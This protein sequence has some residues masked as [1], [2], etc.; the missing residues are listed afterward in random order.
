MFDQKKVLFSGAAAG[1]IALLAFA[2]LCPACSRSSTG[3][4]G[5]TTGGHSGWSGT[6]GGTLLWGVNN[7]NTR[8]NDPL[9][10]LVLI[11]CRTDVNDFDSGHIA[12]AIWINWKELSNTLHTAL[13]ATGVVENFLGKDRG[14]EIT[15]TICLYGGGIE[16]IHNSQFRL[17]WMLEYYGCQD[18]HILNAGLAEWQR[19]GM[20]VS[21]EKWADITIVPKTFTAEINPDVFADRAEIAFRVSNFDRDSHVIVDARTPAE[22]NGEAVMYIQDRA[23]R[24]PGAGNVFWADCFDI[25]S[26]LLLD[27]AAVRPFFE[28]A[29]VFPGKEITLYSTAGV[30]STVLYFMCRLF[31]YPSQIY[32]AGLQDWCDVD[33]SDPLFVERSGSYI[34]KSMENNE[35]NSTF[36]GVS[37]VYGDKIWLFGGLHTP[38]SGKSCRINDNGWRFDPTLHP[39]HEGQDPTCWT[40]LSLPAGSARWAHTAVADTAGDAFYFF[41][42]R[43]P[44]KK[45][46]DT[47]ARID[48]DPVTL[49]FTGGKILNL[50]LPAP[51][52]SSASVYNPV[53]GKIYLIGGI[54]T[55]G[56]ATDTLYAFTPASQGTPAITALAPLPSPRSWCGA[57]AL[58]GKIYCFGGQF[59]N[60]VLL[61]EILEYDPAQD[62]WTTLDPMFN[63]RM[64]AKGA[65]AHGRI[66]VAGGFTGQRGPEGF[67]SGLAESF[68]PAKPGDG[69]RREETMK[70]EKFWHSMESI[71]DHIYL[72]GGYDGH[73]QAFDNKIAFAN[74]VEFSPGFQEARSDLPQ[75]AQ[76][77]GATA[78]INDR[79]YI[80]GGNTEGNLTDRVMEYDTAADSWSVMDVLPQGAIMGA[81]AVVVGQKV[82][83]FGG[84]GQAGVSR[85]TWLFDPAASAGSQWSQ[86][87]A[88][89]EDR[90]AASAVFFDDTLSQF[91]PAHGPELVFVVGGMDFNDFRWS[92]TLLYDVTDD[93]W[94]PA[95]FSPLARAKSWAVAA[96]VGDRLFS[97][98]GIDDDGN[99]LSDCLALDLSSPLLQW[100]S[101]GPLPSARYGQGCAVI[102][103]RIVVTGGFVDDGLGNTAATG[104]VDIL[105]GV[106]GNWTAVAELSE[107]LGFSFVAPSSNGSIFLIGGMSIDPGGFP[108]TTY[109]KGVTEYKP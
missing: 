92:T 69:W 22:Y 105:N 52:C 80:F 28:S 70:V 45:I 71:D 46:L 32:L 24:V 3:F 18:V 58:D 91:F 54:G 19:Q 43:S 49:A 41:G 97:I 2:L 7:L 77:A 51:L 50:K 72:F 34:F 13:P 44:G 64:G 61:D 36:A 23:G 47:I 83:L 103:D 20:A 85:E 102:G 84:S 94:E 104:A 79:I 101:V 53:D 106:S 27:P 12:G 81:S 66:Y 39:L 60:D 56:M 17:F 16:D 78:E 9:S 8:L 108:H 96:I 87:S 38:G 76:S 99:P 21:T 25:E 15:D 74:T 29:G 82:L 93:S 42:G 57:A 11:D 90:W 30:R 75:Q 40:A 89:P 73:P 26:G 37:I 100:T 14:I 1:M 59:K 68:D 86:K 62:T 5:I 63:S 48:V 98:G 95:G 35:R 67:A 88:M 65:V 109:S 107:P 10:E 55:D 4:V 33:V 6:P 31:G